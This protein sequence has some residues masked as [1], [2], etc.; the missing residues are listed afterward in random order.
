MLRGLGDPALTSAVC[1]P[2]GCGSGVG[3]GS[4]EGATGLVGA[5]GGS[6]G[7]TGRHGSSP[8]ATGSAGFFF[9]SVATSRAA[10]D[11]TTPGFCCVNGRQ[12]G[13]TGFPAC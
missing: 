4:R 7:V 3:G 2:C 12:S 6:V 11:I 10:D 9:I 8:P 1:I 5:G 13:W